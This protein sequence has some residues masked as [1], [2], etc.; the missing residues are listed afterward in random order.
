VVLSC[1]A[2][3]QLTD[4]RPPEQ[5]CNTTELGLWLEHT[6]STA[7]TR[8][9]WK[10]AILGSSEQCGN[11]RVGGVFGVP[12]F[13]GKDRGAVA[14]YV[15]MFFSLKQILGVGLAF[16]WSCYG[17]RCGGRASLEDVVRSM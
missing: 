16:F 4:E 7:T 2:R 14:A 13:F 9:R 1:W 11:M 6:T 15:F 3:V 8:R 17:V 12:S 5:L 10:V